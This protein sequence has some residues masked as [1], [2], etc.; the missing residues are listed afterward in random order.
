MKDT[1]FFDTGTR[2]RVGR[3]CC[4]EHFKLHVEKTKE[5]AF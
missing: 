5:R 2:L 4:G 3:N 1:T